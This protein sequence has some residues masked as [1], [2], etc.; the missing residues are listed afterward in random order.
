MGK[1]QISSTKLQAKFKFNNWSKI[2]KFRISKS[3]TNLQ[4]IEIGEQS[5]QK[6]TLPKFGFVL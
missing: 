2:R 6:G 1:S 3:E 5:K 4:K